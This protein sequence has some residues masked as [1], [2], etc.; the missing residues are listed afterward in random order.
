MTAPVS[1]NAEFK[2]AT[3]TAITTA[4][5]ANFVCGRMKESI[6][7]PV[8]DEL[9]PGAEHHCG[10][11]NRPTLNK[12]QS[13]R[14]GYMAVFGGTWF[15]YPE[16]IGIVLRGLGFDKAVSG[17]TPDFTHTFTI[18]DRDDAVFVTVLQQ[19]GDGAAAFERR[20][21]GGRIAQFDML[22]NS[23]GIVCSMQGMAVDIDDSAGTETSD[24]EPGYLITA[25]DGSL[26]AEIDS[27]PIVSNMKIRSSRLSIKNP[28]DVSDVTLFSP[29]RA[30][31]PQLGITADGSLMGIDVS[32]TLWEKLYRGGA[33]SGSPSLVIPEM[34]LSFKYESPSNIPT[35]AIPFSFQVEVPKAEVRMTRYMPSGRN[36]IR[37]GLEWLMR[38]DGSEPITITLC[39]DR[40]TYV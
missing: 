15:L 36:L 26:T 39:N 21:V 1:V 17:T 8:F 35:G 40:A 13:I 2:I 16:M 24:D 6:L 3:Q 11:S 18:A 31:L 32:E 7:L 30:D 38:D 4:A 37:C 33:S 20:G 14:T 5:S 22:A 23:K 27:T 19:I 25:T 29:E 12:S 9:N 28:L 34:D 10:N